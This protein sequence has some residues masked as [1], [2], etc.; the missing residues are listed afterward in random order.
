M[1]TGFNL[2]ENK[3]LSVKTK[4]SVVVVEDVGSSQGEFVTQV[5]G[6]GEQ[7]FSTKNRD[8]PLEK[9]ERS[10]EKA[11]FENPESVRIETA[12]VAADLG[13][14][15]SVVCRDFIKDGDKRPMPAECAA[16]TAV[17]ADEYVDVVWSSTPVHIYKESD[18]FTFR[19]SVSQAFLKGLSGV[20]DTCGLPLLKVLINLIFTLLQLF[21]VDFTYWPL[22]KS[23]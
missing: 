7:V 21:L 15:S 12:C 4:K 3:I 9:L 10:G 17:E 22:C 18:G 2:N 8:V 1:A 23:F 6:A 19:E 13:V 5:A 11:R 14:Q 20:L 16:I